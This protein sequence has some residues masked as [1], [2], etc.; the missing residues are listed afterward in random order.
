MVSMCS[1]SVLSVLLSDSRVECNT[2]GTEETMAT[3][4]SEREMSEEFD[5]ERDLGSLEIPEEYE[6][7]YERSFYHPY[8]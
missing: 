2:E 7:M 5:G 4:T 1:N 6:E 8:G 3:P